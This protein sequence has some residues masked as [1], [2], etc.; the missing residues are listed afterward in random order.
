MEIDLSFVSDTFA[1]ITKAIENQECELIKG[2]KV[3]D[4]YADENGKSIKDFSS[5]FK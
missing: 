3:V 1:P 2:I 5:I 4:T